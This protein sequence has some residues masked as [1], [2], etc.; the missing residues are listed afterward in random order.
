MVWVVFRSIQQFG[1]SYLA[2]NHVFWLIFWRRGAQKVDFKKSQLLTSRHSHGSLFWATEMVEPILKPSDNIFLRIN[3]EKYYFP[4][5]ILTLIPNVSIGCCSNHLHAGPILTIFATIFDTFD[6]FLLETIAND[7]TY[8]KTRM[9]VP[10]KTENFA[11]SVKKLVKNWN[12][13]FSILYCQ[14]WPNFW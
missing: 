3:E 10:P 1:G 4:R 11:K 6:T 7:I 14:F 9:M 13:L 2:K 12:F 8:S 5:K